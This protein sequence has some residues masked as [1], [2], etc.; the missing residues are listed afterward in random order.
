M[1]RLPNAAA[2]GQSGSSANG[3]FEPRPL[4]MRLAKDTPTEDYSSPSLVTRRLDRSSKG[5][6]FPQQAGEKEDNSRS[7][8][9]NARTKRFDEA[10]ADED[11]DKPEDKPDPPSKSAAVHSP[12]QSS[13]SPKNTVRFEDPV[14]SKKSEAPKQKINPLLNVKPVSERP[15]HNVCTT[16]FD[17]PSL[18]TRKLQ[19]ASRPT[20]MTGDDNDSVTRNSPKQMEST[21]RLVD[22]ASSKPRVQ[23]ITPRATFL[24][25]LSHPDSNHA[26]LQKGRQKLNDIINKSLLKMASVP[27]G[28]LEE[29][30]AKLLLAMEG[31]EEGALPAPTTAHDSDDD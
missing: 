3:G 26:K 13:H 11:E 7:S 15:M 21:I 16:D 14:V 29:L 30:R 2:D 5:K 24:R 25:S 18:K 27:D 9:A 20:G 1:N 6:R 17:S 10:L 8:R 22:L 12:R 31:L 28:A 19:A 4:G 23:P